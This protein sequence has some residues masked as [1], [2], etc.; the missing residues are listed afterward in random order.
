[1]ENEK[2]LKRE[3]NK[4]EKLLY[5]TY[6]F[7]MQIWLEANIIVAKVYFELESKKY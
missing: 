1:L 4:L 5:E 7:D 6:N 3:V 2:E